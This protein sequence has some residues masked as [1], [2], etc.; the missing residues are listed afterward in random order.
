MTTK[1]YDETTFILSGQGL[2]G[3]GS[4]AVKQGAVIYVSGGADAMN[5]A[6]APWK[7]TID[8]TLESTS[9]HGLWLIGNASASKVANSTVTVGTEG[10]V[11]GNGA[12][13]VGVYAQQATDIVN[14]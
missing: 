5:L 11:W 10:T 9:L 13:T 2:S 3:G 4:V 12:N 6:D 1:I 8:G 14:S 7:V